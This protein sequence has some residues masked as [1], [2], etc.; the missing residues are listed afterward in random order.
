MKNTDR[1]Q[2]HP[3]GKSDTFTL[4]EVHA[5]AGMTMPE[6]HATS[7]AVIVVKTGEAVLKMDGKEQTLKSG[8]TLILPSGRPHSLHINEDFN[9]IVT[10]TANGK[11]EF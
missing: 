10:L 1:P 11:I 2:M 7:E 8:D 5:K 4:L 3:L 9:A 6:H